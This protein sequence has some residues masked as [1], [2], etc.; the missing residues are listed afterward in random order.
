MKSDE[1]MSGKS[2]DVLSSECR[3]TLVCPYFSSKLIMEMFVEG[4]TCSVQ[5]KY[6]GPFT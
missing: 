1:A 6:I 4:D 2:D 3:P 5:S